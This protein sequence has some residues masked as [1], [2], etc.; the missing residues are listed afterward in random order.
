MKLREVS[1]VLRKKLRANIE[2]S[3]CSR[4][5]N[6]PK[7]KSTPPRGSGR[8]HKAFPRPSSVSERKAYFG[9]KEQTG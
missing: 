7:E 4:L 5:A 1:I 8:I 9:M 6:I 3:T 2:S